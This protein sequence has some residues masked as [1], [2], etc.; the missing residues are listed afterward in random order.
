MDSLGRSDHF[1]ESG[2][3]QHLRI[4]LLVPRIRNAQ[5]GMPSKRI[6]LEI[7]RFIVLGS[8]RCAQRTVVTLRGL[9][10][11]LTIGSCHKC[12]RRE[13]ASDVTQTSATTRRAR[14]QN[15]LTIGTGTNRRI[16]IV[17]TRLGSLLNRSLLGV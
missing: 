8:I 17:F 16:E 2:T 12:A 10:L 15:V 1:L 9:R 5:K 4:P 14:N 6:V 13:S 11:Q 7:A 3:T